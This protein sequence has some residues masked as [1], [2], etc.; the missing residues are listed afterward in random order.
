M[1]D[2]GNAKY[3]RLHISA[4]VSSSKVSMLNF[5]RSGLNVMQVQLSVFLHLVTTGALFS[6]MLF[7]NT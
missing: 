5:A 4:T 2:L 6:D 3:V 7:L 1:S